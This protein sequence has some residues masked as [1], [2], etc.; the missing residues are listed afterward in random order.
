MRTGTLLEQDI[1]TGCWAGP[2]GE[3]VRLCQVTR[4]AVSSVKHRVQDERETGQS[5]GWWCCGREWRGMEGE[6]PPSLGL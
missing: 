4:A 5:W 2:Q 3:G 6:P 1:P